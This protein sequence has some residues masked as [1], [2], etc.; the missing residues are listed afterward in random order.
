MWYV[1]DI[2]F[3]RH[4]IR[5]FIVQSWY[6]MKKKKS[7]DQVVTI[8]K[9]LFLFFIRFAQSLCEKC[10]GKTYWPSEHTFALK[11]LWIF[12]SV[13]LH[14]F[15]R[16]NWSL[17]NA[18]VFCIFVYLFVYLQVRFW[19]HFLWCSYWRVFHCFSLN[20]GLVNGCGWAHWVYGIQYIHGLVALEYHPALLHCL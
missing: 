19:Y 2:T 8:K 12:S 9:C 18:I 16:G 15:Y 1:E 3:F 4:F 10:V 5:K 17:S 11:T 13:S 7:V 6:E 14:I 20:W